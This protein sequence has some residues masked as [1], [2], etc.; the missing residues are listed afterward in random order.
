MKPKR[1][2]R[3]AQMLI[4]RMYG[5]VAFSQVV[6]EPQLIETS[7]KRLAKDYSQAD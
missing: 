3:Q 5:M 4:A 7:L 1:A 6:N 2:R